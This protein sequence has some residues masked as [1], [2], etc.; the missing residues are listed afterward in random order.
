MKKY[1]PKH[2]ESVKDLTRYERSRFSKSRICYI[3]NHEIFDDEPFVM[4]KR[5]IGSR[6]CYLFSHERIE[7]CER[8]WGSMKEDSYAEI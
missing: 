1:K 3:C 4:L 7:D 8:N 6:V 2:C 5:P